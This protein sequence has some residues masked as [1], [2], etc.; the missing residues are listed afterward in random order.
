ME[1]IEEGNGKA[2]LYMITKFDRKLDKTDTKVVIIM[3]NYKM[4]DF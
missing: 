3:E 4:V 1:F 2:S